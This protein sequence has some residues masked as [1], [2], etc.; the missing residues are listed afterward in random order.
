MGH[1]IFLSYSRQ[2]ADIMQ[3]LRDDFRAAGFTVWTD[4]GIDPGSASWKIEIEEAIH[5]AMCL[6][7]IFSPG[8]LA[9]RWV[10]AELDYAEAQKKPIFAVLAEGDE[11]NAVPFG[12]S[13]HQWIDL[14]TP[15]SY[16]PNF[17]LLTI[18]LTN[19]LGSG[20]T[21]QADA[22]YPVT[23]P[24]LARSTT[25]RYRW[26]GLAV[27]AVML[28]TAAVVF[29][30]GLNPATLP[31]ETAI[32]IEL[33][34]LVDLPEGWETHQTDR[35]TISALANWER[36]SVT[37]EIFAAFIR[38]ILPDYDPDE[39]LAQLSGEEVHLYL[40][41]MLRLQGL[42]LFRE[43]LGVTLPLSVLSMRYQDVISANGYEIAET[44][45]VQLPAGE[46]MQIMINTTDTSAAT[47]SGVV[48][49]VY[50]D[51][52]A[53]I[54]IFAAGGA[55]VDLDAFIQLCQQMMGTLSFPS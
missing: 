46:A 8:A 9:S 37:S 5:E 38:A 33:S 11:S 31:A 19:A 54:F 6:V 50:H 44:Q 17:K 4:E 36:V 52:Q 2:N 13:S 14:R 55:T 32:P 51:Q 43:D 48:Y 7:V 1:H 15:D 25:A 16:A 18:A 23:A 12:Y 49:V 10:R 34:A 29:S 35:L 3:R 26:V 39:G 45:P 53:F 47:G 22:A 30:R 28:V 42:F 20:E 27:V 24:K 41:D 40:G 21:L